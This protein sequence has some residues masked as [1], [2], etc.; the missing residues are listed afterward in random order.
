MDKNTENKT[1]D[2]R[3]AEVTDNTVVSDIAAVADDAK[4]R[5]GMKAGAD[6]EVPQDTGPAS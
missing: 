5:T 3:N 4:F 2:Q 1:T 6:T